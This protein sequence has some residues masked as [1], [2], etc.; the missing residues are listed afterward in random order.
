MRR[1][2]AFFAASAFVFA[3]CSSPSHSAFVPS[4]G[5]PSLSLKNAAVTE[6]I[7]HA[8][9]GGKTDGAIP[10]SSLT[11]VGALFYGTTGLG[12]AHDAGTI[13]SIRPNGTGFRVRYSFAGSG[14]LHGV[15]PSALTYVDGTLYGTTRFGG[16]G[17][18]GTVFSIT[19]AG[20]FK[21]LYAF[22]GGK[23]DGAHPLAAL[24]NV[25]GTLYGTTND[26]GKNVGPDHCL[27]CGA[28]FS[29]TKTGKERVLY[30]FGAKAADGI[31]P[32]HTS[33]VLRD[34]KLY[35][36]TLEGGNTGLGTIFSITVA[37]KEAVVYTFQGASD[38]SCLKDCYL[39]DVGGTL[40]GTARTGG[41][42]GFGSVFSFSGTG[43][44]ETLYSASPSGNDGGQPGAALTNV[45]G[46]LY[47]TMSEGPTGKD[48]GTVFSITPTGDFTL[49]YTFAGG[50]DGSNPAASMSFAGGK[51]YGTTNR[52]GKRNG[53]TIFSLSGF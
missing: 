24:T 26:G 29:V 47:G 38:G 40:Y 27:N 15:D 13:F 53:G 37:G 33:L 16:Y 42:S 17:D 1:I 49:L 32:G 34:S 25:R 8:F 52:G 41:K 2:F 22:K 51:L 46:T 31:G 11:M 14:G 4:S 21:L 20:S 5:G 19:P 10:I 28:V 39:T 9:M 30:F 48:N 45:A 36:T 7:L 43:A 44:F 6:K 50:T 35:G 18:E 12:G 3:G 23:A